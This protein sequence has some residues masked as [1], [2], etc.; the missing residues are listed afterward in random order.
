MRIARSVVVLGAVIARR[1]RWGSPR[2][3][4]GLYVDGDAGPDEKHGTAG[5]DVLCGW[6]GDDQLYGGRGNDVIRG[7][8][9]T[10]S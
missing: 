5:D 9:V 8:P 4:A 6:G 3:R 1:S 7:G 2:W 10:T